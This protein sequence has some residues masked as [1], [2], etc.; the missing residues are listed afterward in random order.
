MT[1]KEQFLGALTTAYTNLFLTDSAYAYPASRMSPAELAAKM[2]DGL[3][4][5]RANHDGK[6]I[7]TACKMVGIKH[8]ATAIRT[9]LN[10]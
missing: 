6:G 2:T 7:R 8:T 1:N 5:G 10:T 3:A 4:A 9:F